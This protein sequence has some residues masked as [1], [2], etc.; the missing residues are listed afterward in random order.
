MSIKSKIKGFLAI[1][2]SNIRGASS[3]LGILEGNLS[4]K[5]N[6]DNL[7]VSELLQL[8]IQHDCHISIIDNKSGHEIITFNEYDIN[9]AMDPA[10]KETKE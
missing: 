7:K 8:C 5:L 6:N 4:R 9:P 1:K 2:N 3:C 10:D